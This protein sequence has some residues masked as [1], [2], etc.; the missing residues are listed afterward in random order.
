MMMSYGI[1]YMWTCEK[2]GMSY[3]GQTITTLNQRWNGHLQAANGKSDWE[4]PKAI[5]EHG[6]ESFVGIILCECESS[7]ELNEKE[8]YYINKFDTVFPRGY[9]MTNGG[10]GPCQLTR[11]LIS[12]RTKEAMTQLD[13]SYKVKQ[14]VAMKDQTVRQKISERTKA[15]MQRPDVKAKIAAIWDET[16]A[17]ISE[18]LRGHVLSDETK[19]KIAETLRSKPKKLRSVKECCRCHENFVVKKR[20]QKYCTSSCYKTRGYS[21][22]TSQ[23]T[24]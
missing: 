24:R 1:V 5:R 12:K 22:G 7:E 21:N 16:R 17:K 14:R 18:T 2:T 11:Q 8:K 20:N 4:F 23:N 3:I 19:K 9:N 6:K 10:E 15:A 13:P